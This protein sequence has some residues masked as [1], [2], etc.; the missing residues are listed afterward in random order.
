MHS[1]LNLGNFVSS[2]PSFFFLS[3]TSPARAMK[4]RQYHAEATGPFVVYIRELN[5]PLQPIK[6]SVHIHRHYPSTTSIMKTAPG[7]IKVVLQNKVEANRF[8]LDTFFKDFRVYIPSIDCES[9][10]IIEFPT[11]ED[12]STLEESGKGKCKNPTI[13]LVNIISAHRLTKAGEATI[14]SDTP[15]RIDIPLVR[16]HFSGT[17]LP[18]YVEIMGLLI[19]VEIPRSKP[20][21]CGRCQNYGHTELYCKKAVKCG[22]CNE[23]HRTAECR[24]VNDFCLDCNA[25]GHLGG[26]EACPKFEVVRKR[27]VAKK[28]HSR[29]KSFADI[30]KASTSPAPVV[31]S[32]AGSASTSAQC[33]AT[34]SMF[35]QSG[36]QRIRHRSTSRASKR[37]R[38]A[39]SPSIGM[40]VYPPRKIRQKQP[41]SSEEP[42][43]FAST[44]GE[45][46]CTKL[47]QDLCQK[48]GLSPF[49]ANICQSVVVPIVEVL[50]SKFSPLLAPILSFLNAY[51]G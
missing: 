16:V 13:P 46:S 35:A 15:T 11:D 12:V 8:V 30:V 49:W 2:P 42:R 45:F 23:G 17:L 33:F 18:D 20:M 32:A 41:P 25:I 40:G 26:T 3:M 44:P 14:D 38:N 43:G 48:L 19:K 4:P 10:G 6:F 37:G 34:P 31:G 9:V 7:R 47:I 5:S 1:G 50:V 39:R 21:F 22:K 27:N 36:G 29:K 51:N 24:I 28:V